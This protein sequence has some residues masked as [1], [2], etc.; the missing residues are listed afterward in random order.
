M[1]SGMQSELDQPLQGAMMIGNVMDRR[2]DWRSSAG[3]LM[4]AGNQHG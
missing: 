2:C 1:T 3:H 4:E